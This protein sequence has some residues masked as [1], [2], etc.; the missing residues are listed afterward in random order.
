MRKWL[1]AIGAAALVSGSTALA[2]FSGGFFD[3]P[4]VV[5][6]LAAWVGV[7]LVAVAAPKPLPESTAG[8]VALGGLFL[9]CV[10]TGL[11]IAWAPIGGRAQDDL[12]RLLLYLGFFITAVPLL[13][14][15]GARRWLEPGLVLGAFVIVGYALSERLLPGIIELNRSS[16][17]AG[18]LEQP[19]TYWNALGIVA[20]VGTVLAVR[21]AGTPERPKALRAA[22]AAAGV[23]LV[24]PDLCARRARSAGAGHGRTARAR[25]SG[26]PAVAQHRRDR[27]RRRGCSSGRQQP[28]RDQVA[29]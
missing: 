5:A 8:R 29:Q 13:R 28:A 10:W 3:R 2:F 1:L 6:A 16:A 18:R 17:A 25:A 26:A 20:A 21:I 22:G 19:L 11:S 23:P 4:R 15:E 24:L 12:Q 27:C 14:G 9:L 7:I